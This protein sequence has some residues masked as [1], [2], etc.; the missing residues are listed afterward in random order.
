MPAPL[1]GQLLICRRHKYQLR[2]NHFSR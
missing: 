1:S 2:A